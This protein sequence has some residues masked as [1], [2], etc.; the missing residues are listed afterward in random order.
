VLAL[1]YL[2]QNLTLPPNHSD[3]GLVLD[4][5]HQM[6]EGARPFWD[7]I[8]LYGPLCWV[9]PVLAYEVGGQQVWA[10]GVAVLLT[11]LLSI[12]LAYRLV[13]RLAGRLPAWLAAFSLTV[14][15]GAPWQLLQIPYAMHPTLT[16]TLAVWLL[17]L[18]PPREDAAASVPGPSLGR[19]A[20]AGALA[21]CAFWVKLNAGA[22]L[23]A[24]GLFYC[25][26]WLPGSR[27]RRGSPAPA[28]LRG[29]AYAGLA[30]Y[31]A[32]FLLF[33]RSGW[34]ELFFYYLVAPLVAALAL[35]LTEVRTRPPDR[36]AALHRLRAWGVFLGSALGVIAA[37][38]L[39]YFGPEGG[40]V[41]AQEI[42]AILARLDYEAP[43]PRLGEA[44]RYVGFNEYYWPQLPWLVSLSFLAAAGL[45]RRRTS[46]TEGTGAGARATLAGLFALFT[47]Q[48]FV[49][50]SR[51]DESH[52][53]QAAWPA[54]PALFVMLGSVRNALGRPL[55]TGLAVTA[56][57]FAMT[58]P[59]IAI[60]PEGY[61]VR[62]GDWHSPHLRHLDFH[63]PKEDSPYLAQDSPHISNRDWDI[64]ANRVARHV[65]RLTPDGSEVL[66]T[67]RNELIQLNS[68]TRAV[69]GRHR[70]LFYL[71]KQGLLSGEEF[72]ELVPDAV[73]R[74]LVRDPPRVIV[75]G[76]GRR[77]AEIFEALPELHERFRR[78]YEPI[79]SYAHLV[80][81]ERR[82]SA[83]ARAEVAPETHPR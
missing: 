65:D 56:G 27:G 31:G 80:I 37:F 14:L 66:V 36:A 50:Y 43:F 81:F 4:Y 63:P 61:R 25:F 45:A 16:L 10:V 9:A 54:V 6:S 39:G 44:G 23:L 7:F 74:S 12:V 55:W 20:L 24:G 32:V 19:V 30:A 11:K 35:T 48:T 22:F 49:I 59:L 71:L 33:V 38:F 83:A 17:L 69:G 76:Y 1:L 60:R 8:D 5:V 29:A 15:L 18:A 78:E 46:G 21:G 75:H 13:A 28:W 79:A 34:Q 73:I 3:G 58:L 70:Y 64:A 26:Y 68:N 67:A 47:L 53:V 77:T 82:G 52:L 42:G 51:A 40:L 72:R 62:P 41:Y 2:G 57:T